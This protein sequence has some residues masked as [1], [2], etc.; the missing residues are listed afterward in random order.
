MKIKVCGMKYEENIK[1]VAALEPDYLG[2]I[3]YGKSKRNFEGQIPEITKDIKKAGVFVNA[4]ESF[5]NAMVEEHGLDAINYMEMNRT[6]IV[7]K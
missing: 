3:F 1:S 4:S 2:F 5:I 7:L 6:H